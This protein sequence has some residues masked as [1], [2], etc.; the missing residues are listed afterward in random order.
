MAFKRINYNESI[1]YYLKDYLKYKRKECHVNTFQKFFDY[2]IEEIENNEKA[3]KYVIGLLINDSTGNAVCY[4]HSWIE[5]NNSVVD[6]TP[7]ANMYI[8][9]PEQLVENEYKEFVRQVNES[10]YM[11]L[12]TVSNANLNKELNNLLRSGDD[13]Q[14][15]GKTMEKLIRQWI[16]EA[17]KDHIIPE[18]VRKNGLKFIDN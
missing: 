10:R 2:N 14:K 17:E 4:I 13:L 18:I 12:K 16:E 11:P 15:P 6:V 5:K 3:F 9:S 8:S 7:F 1:K